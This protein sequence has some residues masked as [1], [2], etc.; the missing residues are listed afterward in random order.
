M[1]EKYVSLIDRWG[2]DVDSYESGISSG[3]RRA[4]C[5]ECVYFQTENALKCEKY[6]NS[7]KPS[8]VLHSK[9][10]CKYFLSKKPIE[11][12]VKEN[13][14]ESKKFGALFG[15]VCG[16]MIGVPVEFENRTERRED[17]VKNARAYGTYNQPIGTWSDDTSLT[18]ALIDC[19]NKGFSISSLADGFVKFLRQAK[20]TPYGKVFDIGNTTITAIS[21]IEK[22]IPYSKCGGADES[23]NGNGSL[24]RI[25]PMG[26]IWEDKSDEE[27]IPLIEDI[28]RLTHGHP[29]SIFACL[30][31]AYMIKELLVCD[32]KEVALDKTIEYFNQSLFDKKYDQERES[33]NRI[34]TKDIISANEDSIKST[35]YVVD[36]LEAALWCFFSENST[37]DI[38][39]KAVNLGGDTDTIAAIAGGLAGT[40]YGVNDIPDNWIQLMAQ[41]EMLFEMFKT[42]V[43]NK[44]VSS[45]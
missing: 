23:D 36:S 14:V 32:S 1:E 28:S 21:N 34:F 37:K 25:L 29:R 5:K 12:N 18:L 43:S 11:I 7:E 10:E 8:E 2:M 41:K 9:R 24:M 35:G 22:G 39:L 42:F 20:Y 17:P 27:M 26:L 38:I 6:I 31:Y 15:F 45:P 40:F 4:F 33:Y 13:I 16:D 44:E 30:F 3:R 19:I